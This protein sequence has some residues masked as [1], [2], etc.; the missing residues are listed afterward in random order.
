MANAPRAP[1]ALFIYRRIDSTARVLDGLEACAG[2]ADT[3]VYVFSDAA[4]TPDIAHEVE[5]V[6]AMV[7]ARLRPNMSLVAR[8]QNMGL[9]RSVIEGV[10]ELCAAHGRAIV[11]EDD[12]VPQPAFLDWF[13]VALERYAG[14]PKVRQIAAYMF[15][16][17]SIRESG[18]AVLLRHPTSK[19]WAVWQRSWN[20]F[21]PACTGWQERF[22]DAGFRKRFAIGH[23]MRFE[24]MFR[25]QM[26]GQL[27]SWAIRFHYSVIETD[28]LVVYPPQS[29]VADIGLEAGKATHGQRSAGL[30][31]RLRLWEEG[32]PPPMP[33]VGPVVADDWAIRAWIGRLRMSPYGLAVLAARLRYRV[34][35]LLG[36]RSRK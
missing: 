25:M 2:F 35:S 6:R 27:N 12:L 4:K 21:D 32:V 3:P 18:R 10:G 34:Q 15:D 28:G 26:A 29:L 14:E 11:I 13:D 9:A 36:R 22:Q 33:P 16:I 23:A 8:E 17:A 1:L 7:R 31:P 24:D 5:A 30:L 20:R 19:G